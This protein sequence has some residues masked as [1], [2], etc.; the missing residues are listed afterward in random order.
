MLDIVG[1]VILAAVTALNLFVF[2]NSLSLSERARGLIA[3]GAGAWIGLAVA[4]GSAG[5]LAVAEPFPVM[6][7]FVAA[8]L[9]AA[10][11][12][13]TLSSAFREA[14]LALPAK[15]IVAL[16]IGRIFGGFFLLLALQ[17]RLAGPFPYSAGWGDV[18]TG[19]AALWFLASPWLLQ[20]KLALQSWNLFGALDLIVAVVLGV[21]SSSGSPL[22]LIE[23]GIG[24]HAVQYMPWALI[25]S[26]LVPFYL[27]LHGVMIAKA[28]HCTGYAGRLAAGT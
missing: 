2:L 9:I 11:A 10:A 13:A 19:A 3:L 7:V 15:T 25:P 20:S 16:N 28:A 17:G 5:G 26:V 22:Q 14:L 24:S 21:I 18:I 27:I 6:G 1:A 23:A 12:G 4:I 8:P